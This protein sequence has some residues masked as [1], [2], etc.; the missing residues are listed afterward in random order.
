MTPDNRTAI[1]EGMPKPKTKTRD[2]QAATAQNP[3][4]VTRRQL[5]IVNCAICEQPLPHEPGHAQAV[6]TQ[7]YN[8]AHLDELTGAAASR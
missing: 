8:D 6:L 1:L 7:H 4:P 2:L 3:A 5:P